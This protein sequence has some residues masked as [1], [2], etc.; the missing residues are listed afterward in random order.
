MHWDLIR[1]AM[2][3]VANQAVFPLQDI[4]GLGTEARMNFPGKAEGNWQWRYTEGMLN[5]EV[6]DRLR[7]MTRIYGRLPQQP[8][9]RQRRQEAEQQGDGHYHS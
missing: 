9:Q 2:N 4:L 3:S 6:G 1:L 7:F 8:S 5:A